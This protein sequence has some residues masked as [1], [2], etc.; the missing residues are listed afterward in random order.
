M[1]KV[2]VQHVAKTAGTS[3]FHFLEPNFSYQ[4]TYTSQRFWETW[5]KTPASSQ[6][7]RQAAQPMLTRIPPEFVLDKTFLHGHFRDLVRQ[8]L[9]RDWTTIGTSRSV[10]SRLISSYNH[11]LRDQTMDR[12]VVS[13]L[14]GK[15]IAHSDILKAL[16]S[17]SQ[18]GFYATRAP[19]LSMWLV[20][21]ENIEA[22]IER[23]AKEALENIDAYDYIV[24]S[25]RFEEHCGHLGSH[26]RF[27]ANIGTFNSRESFGQSS[28]FNRT[29]TDI[30]R[31][32]FPVFFEWEDKIR[33][34][35]KA[36]A[37]H[38]LNRPLDE[39]LEGRRQ[40]QS[41]TQLLHPDCAD[42]QGMSIAIPASLPGWEHSFYRAMNP[43]AVLPNIELTKGHY[44]AFT[45]LW[46]ADNTRFRHFTISA[47]A[48]PDQR[49]ETILIENPSQH[50]WLVQLNF[51]V[52]TTTAI[53][54]QL[55]SPDSEHATMWLGTKIYGQE[56]LERAH[57]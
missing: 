28:S 32:D 35:L 55:E 38:S 49:A 25:S 41:R 44:T 31:R 18:I 22:D 1:Q 52:D 5:S 40:Q 39:V 45:W 30:L 37:E 51:S 16:V 24:D 3:L 27:S 9:C 13:Y 42:I 26:L 14:Q 47:G 7:T 4:S 11:Q 17:N 36:K 10:D 6:E 43:V 48:C 34:K 15:A 33:E 57:P 56:P 23:F 8:V 2:F 29:H 20:S 19:R 53:N 46:C 21:D 50:L 54:L 12:R